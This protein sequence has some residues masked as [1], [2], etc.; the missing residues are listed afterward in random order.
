MTTRSPF[1][2]HLVPPLL[3][4][5]LKV[6]CHQLN[7]TTQNT[8]AKTSTHTTQI[9]DFNCGPICLLTA[10]QLIT[11]GCLQKLHGSVA[12]TYRVQIQN[13]LRPFVVDS[14]PIQPPIVVPTLKTSEKIPTKKPLLLMK[15]L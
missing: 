4:I 1:T 14:T 5:L 10:E 12:K 8:A 6:I 3:V 7:I 2:S 13:V 9:D 11:S 15:H